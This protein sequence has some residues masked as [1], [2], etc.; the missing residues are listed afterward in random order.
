MNVIGQQ[1]R[2][3]IVAA[4]L[5]LTGLLRPGEAQT[6]RF[7]AFRDISLP[8]NANIRLGP[9][10]SDWAIMLSAGYRYVTSSGPGAE[11]LYRDEKGRYKKDGSDLP[12]VAELTMRNY[13]LISR[14]MDLD[15]SC[16]LRYNYFPLGT[17]ENWFSFEIAGPALSARMGSF[18]FYMTEK[19]WAG[20]YDAGSGRLMVSDQTWMGTYNGQYVSA[21]TGE[22]G[23]GAAGGY[24]ATVSS[25]F[26]LTPF[27]RGR[28]YDAP[29]YRVD[30]VDARGINDNIS[31][32]SYH[33]FQN[34][35]GIDMDWMMAKDKNLG[36]SA[37]R[38]DTIPL[39]DTGD[40][41][42]FDVS[43]SVV[44]R[45]TLFYQQQ[46]NP[47]CSVG[48]RAD[49]WWR[50]FLS[51][52]RGDQF[53]QDYSVYG[54]MDL[55]ENSSLNASIG[56]SS[57]TLKDPGAY[58]TRGTSET[59]IGAI[60][61]NSKL[62]DHLSHSLGYSRSQ[63]AN[64]DAGL[65]VIDDYHYSLSWV[66]DVWNIALLSSY[67]IYTPRLSTISDY[68]DWVTQLT[69]SRAITRTL[70]LNMTTAYAV[71]KNG[72]VS[73]NDPYGD[74]PMVQNDYST[75]VINGGLNW[76][77]STSLTAFFYAEHLNRYS[78][79]PSMEF[80]RDTVGVNLVYR[81]DI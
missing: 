34:T 21:Y 4:V 52:G 74:S 16:R 56:H 24:S 12:M 70:G 47:L 36:Y 79:D 49:W 75:W 30:Y 61:L 19:T 51:D 64:F 77:L 23:S 68:Q 25:Q 31:G 48:A 58:E 55:T 76:V 11:Y 53:Q 44:Y 37:S 17:E 40:S 73:S 22:G 32:D 59:I 62:T 13:M 2:W 38:T 1:R 46:V 29:S 7:E 3:V 41:N 78:D 35:L 71:R 39:Q 10:Y 67:R 66:R 18:S 6:L 54:I 26:E 45:Q 8:D 20:S 72:N 5:L 42:R 69:T 9:F 27:V 43:K 65:D 81:H 57:A 28:I 80:S 60:Q 33:V 63:T 14:Y 50:Y 15:I